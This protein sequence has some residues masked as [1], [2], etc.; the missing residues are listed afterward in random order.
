MINTTVD[1]RT[2]ALKWWEHE[3]PYEN[4]FL[5]IKK[6]HN[7]ERLTTGLTG[8]EIEAIWKFEKVTENLEIENR[9]LKLSHSQIAEGLGYIAIAIETHDNL[10]REY[11]AKAIRKIIDNAKNITK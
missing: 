7:D 10:D 8:R 11:W 4:K 2:E 5:L 1:T 6:Y 3:V 9:L